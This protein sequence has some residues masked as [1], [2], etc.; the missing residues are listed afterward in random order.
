MAASPQRYSDFRRAVEHVR[1]PQTSHNK[2]EWLAD[3]GRTAKAHREPILKMTKT[4]QGPQQIGARL[5]AKVGDFR[6]LFDDILAKLVNEVLPVQ[7]ISDHQ[8]A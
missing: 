8:Q 5:L 1:R 6:P 7:Q 2:R 3:L 4:G